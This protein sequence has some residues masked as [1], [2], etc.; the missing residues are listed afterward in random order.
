MLH[1]HAVHDDAGGE[2]VVLAGDVLG[3]F[4]AAAA[5]GELLHRQ[6]S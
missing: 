6:T 1:P 2:R 3:E 5:V 4:E